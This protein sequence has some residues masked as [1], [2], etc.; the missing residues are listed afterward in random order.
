MICIKQWLSGHY[1]QRNSDKTEALITDPKT[2]FDSATSYR[3]WIGNCFFHLSS[4][5]EVWIGDDRSCF[6]FHRIKIILISLFTCLNKKVLD[7]LQ[8]LQ[9]FRNTATVQFRIHHNVL[10]LTVGASSRQAPV[11]ISD[12][13]E[14]HTPARSLRSSGPQVSQV[15]LRTHFKTRGDW[16]LQAAALPVSLRR[17]NSAI[18]FES[19]CYLNRR[20]FRQG[21]LWLSHFVGLFFLLLC[22]LLYFYRL[23]FISV[24]FYVSSCVH[25]FLYYCEALLCFLAVRDAV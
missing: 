10:V 8:G 2:I 16:S 18:L 22:L 14:L 25:M 20:L 15:C 21:L 5:V 12:L 13:L 1:L 9:N 3:E 19:C 24:C 4:G 6:S 23:I 7:R 17:L 11:Y